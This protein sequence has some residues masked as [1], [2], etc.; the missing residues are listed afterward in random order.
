MVVKARTG[1]PGAILLVALLTG[2]GGSSDEEDPGSSLSSDE[3]TAA[4]N[5]AAQIV[6][7]G[8]VS[9]QDS[10]ENGVT[11]EESGCIAE[12]AVREVGLEALQDYGIL[13]EDLL[14]D[15]SIQG[16]EMT[17]ADADGLAGV[18]VECINAE[19]L[20]V[21]RFLDTLP[22]GDAEEARECVEDAVD[23]DTVQAILSASFQGRPASDFGRLQ[24]EVSLCTGGERSSQ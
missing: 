2:C 12:G 15:K 23:S 13:T 22:P 11:E 16:V 17:A 3:Q 14:V 18:F 9:G 24:K 20:F 19:E 6:R 5:L 7:S 1:V 8:N 4:D 21:E 10:A